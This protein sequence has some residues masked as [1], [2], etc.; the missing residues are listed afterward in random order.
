M[1]PLHLPSSDTATQSPLRSSKGHKSTASPS[2]QLYSALCWRPHHPDHRPTAQGQ[3]NKNNGVRITEKVKQ[4]GHVP[5]LAKGNYNIS[6]PAKGICRSETRNTEAFSNPKSAPIHNNCLQPRSNQSELNTV[7]NIR[8]IEIVTFHAC[9][10]AIS[11]S[12]KSGEFNTVVIVI[13]YPGLVNTQTLTAG[14]TRL[15]TY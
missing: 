7:S 9:T 3:E 15:Y 13:L 10:Q 8:G 6:L 12:Y 2:S 5:Y 4:T 14:R 11:W 1:S